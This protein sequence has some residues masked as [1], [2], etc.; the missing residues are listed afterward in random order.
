MS[1]KLKKKSKSGFV[2][3]IVIVTMAL[4]GA[5]MYMLSGDCITVMFQSNE[6]YLRAIEHNLL[7]SGLAWAEK[8]TVNGNPDV[9][10]KTISFD[11]ADINAENAALSIFIEKSE[12]NRTEIQIDASCSLGRQKIREHQKYIID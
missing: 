1:L 7:V 11:I 6:L 4:L 12:E 9:F 3:L 8:N 10:N 2:L 5:E